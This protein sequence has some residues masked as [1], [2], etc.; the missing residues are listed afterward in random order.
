MNYLE[1]CVKLAPLHNRPNII[2]IEACKKLMAN[3]PMAVVFDTAFHGTMPK[4]AYMYAL[5]YEM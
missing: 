3:T 5:P 2:G 1:E 4:E